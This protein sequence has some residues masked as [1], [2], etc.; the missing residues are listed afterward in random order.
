M[1]LS[2]HGMQGSDMIIIA[3][4]TKELLQEWKDAIQ[5]AIL[6]FNQSVLVKEGI[7]HKKGHLHSGW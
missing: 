6:T 4:E 7:M 3:A 2:A 1:K 5:G